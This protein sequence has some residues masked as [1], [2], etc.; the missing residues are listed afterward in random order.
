MATQQITR[1]H[2]EEARARIAGIRN[3]LASIR[4]Q[5]EQAT[6]RIVRTAE[7]TGTAFAMG[8]VQGKTGGV[9]V[10]GVPLELIVG[11]GL[12]IAGHLNAAGKMSDHLIN[13]GDGALAAYAVTMGRGIGVTWKNKAAGGGAAPPPAV[14]GEERRQMGDGGDGDLTAAEV[15]AVARAVAAGVR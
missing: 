3:R 5:S 14:K 9:E 10:V 13:A 11:G 15:G 2:L 7:V 4:K 8:V 1:A 6:E 12:A